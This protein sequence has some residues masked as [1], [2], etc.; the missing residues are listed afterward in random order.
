MLYL[1]VSLWSV[2]L[3]AGFAVYRS[4][5]YRLERNFCFLAAVCACSFVH[6]SGAAVVSITHSFS[7]FLTS[8]TQDCTRSR[9]IAALQVNLCI[10]SIVNS[11]TLI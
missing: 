7:P 6:F 3:V 4:A 11:G 9:T 8:Y 1:L 2:L 5:F 10:L